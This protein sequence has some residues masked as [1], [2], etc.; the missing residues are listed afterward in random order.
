MQTAQLCRAD[1]AEIMQ[2]NG[3]VLTQ[4]KWIEEQPP[5]KDIRDWR[6]SPKNHIRAS[7]KECDYVK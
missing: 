2:S 1:K 6:Q 4:T 3:I 7:N 5:K